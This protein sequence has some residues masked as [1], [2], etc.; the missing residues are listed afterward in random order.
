MPDPC[1]WHEVAAHFLLP[2]NKQVHSKP[3]LGSA[4]GEPN[5]DGERAR[6]RGRQFL[7]SVHMGP[8]SRDG[9]ESG[10]GEHPCSFLCLPRQVMPTQAPRVCT[11]LSSFWSLPS[12]SCPPGTSQGRWEMTPQA[13]GQMCWGSSPIPP[14]EAHVLI[15]MSTQLIP[16]PGAGLCTARPYLSRARWV[17]NSNSPHPRG[18]K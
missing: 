13:A 6:I 4:P 14:L 1:G 16:P 3:Q 7:L 11:S 17:G 10:R 2:L 15:A 12:A 5:H 9:L 18:I 8:G